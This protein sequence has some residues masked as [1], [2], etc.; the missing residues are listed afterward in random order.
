LGPAF[1]GNLKVLA[2]QVTDNLI[3]AVERD[4]I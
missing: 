3:V 4:D 1:V 2:G